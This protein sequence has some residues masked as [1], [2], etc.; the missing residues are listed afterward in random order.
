MRPYFQDHPIR[1]PTYYP[2]RQVLQNQ[3]LSGQIAKWAIELG[4][5]DI[6]YISQTTIKAQALADFITMFTEQPRP[7]LRAM[8]KTTVVLTTEG[9]SILVLTSPDESYSWTDHRA[10]G[11]QEKD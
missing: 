2:F 9:R 10:Q 8:E 6:E 3:E 4:K 5:F 11:A 7:T 1:V